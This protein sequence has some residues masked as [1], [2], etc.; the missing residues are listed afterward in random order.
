MKAGAAGGKI[1]DADIGG[2][3]LFIVRPEKK[4]AV[5]A[6]LADLLEVSTRF[7]ETIN[8]IDHS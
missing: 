5:R 1:C 6:A 7:P 3:L 4:A 2:F 8:V